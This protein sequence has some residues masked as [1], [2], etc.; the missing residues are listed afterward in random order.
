MRA[1]SD[2]SHPSLLT[3]TVFWTPEQTPVYAMPNTPWN[4]ETDIAKYMSRDEPSRFVNRQARLPSP[5]ALLGTQK[6][7]AV[8]N[9]PCLAPKPQPQLQP[10]QLPL[11][12]DPLVSS[13][14]SVFST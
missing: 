4:Q 10:S 12:S 11:A 7:M 8:Y 5:A 1:S 2:L 14:P 9:P 3:A 6:D 13:L